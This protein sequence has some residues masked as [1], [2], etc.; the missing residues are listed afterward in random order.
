M[1]TKKSRVFLPQKCKN[2]TTADVNQS[3]T[4]LET[5]TDAE[6]GDFDLSTGILAVTKPGLFQFNFNS[7][8]HVTSIS[9]NRRY[10]LRVNGTVVAHCCNG[11]FNSSA[12]D[13][14]LPVSIFALLPLKC[15]D[16]VGIFKVNGHLHEEASYNYITRL[17][18][19]YLTQNWKVLPWNNDT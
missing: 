8:T 2:H 11:E 9:C 6:F 16:K 4:F 5:D 14:Y 13:L 18:C 10:E 1:F 17:T 12:S 19:K 15:G 7:H 3:F